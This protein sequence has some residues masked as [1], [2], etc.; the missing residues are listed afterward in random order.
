M[1]TELVKKLINEMID[2]SENH[3]VPMNYLSTLMR[4]VMVGVMF[5]LITTI[6]NSELPK[7]KK[8]EGKKLFIKV[9]HEVIDKVDRNLPL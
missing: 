3:P 9:M 1:S 6:Y 4:E 2:E 7:D 5:I 8:E